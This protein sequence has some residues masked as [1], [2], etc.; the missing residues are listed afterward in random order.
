MSEGQRRVPELSQQQK[1]TQS[2]GEE[3]A[4]GFALGPN[5]A[6]LKE[7]FQQ[8]MPCSQVV[9]AD[10]FPGASALAFAGWQGDRAHRVRIDL[11]VWDLLHGREKEA[12]CEKKGECGTLKIAVSPDCRYIAYMGWPDQPS[13]LHVWSVDP[14]ASLWAEDFYATPPLSLAF[15]PGGLL[16]AGTE[17]EIH[18][19]QPDRSVP[20]AEFKLTARNKEG[21]EFLDLAFSPSGRFLLAVCHVEGGRRVNFRDSPLEGRCLDI[22]HESPGSSLH[23]IDMSSR[24]EVSAT[25]R[26]ERAA[27]CVL[28]ADESHAIVGCVD[29]T[30]II[31]SLTD[32]KISELF[33]AHS[34][35][36][37]AMAL[38]ASRQRLATGSEDGSVLYWDIQEFRILGG[39]VSKSKVVALAFDPGGLLVSVSK[40]GLI[41]T[42]DCPR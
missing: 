14:P 37:S 32:G 11:R 39:A 26:L 17:D 8:A 20:P 12:L 23:L 40:D 4:G 33:D 22:L 21:E 13:C 3:P 27:R 7:V 6:P 36:V 1:N 31:Q 24:D 25:I 41:R 29:G 30:L 35:P 15:S 10:F 28:M 9:A 16:A 42:W 2:A 19:R 5:V 18:L 38:D 34:S